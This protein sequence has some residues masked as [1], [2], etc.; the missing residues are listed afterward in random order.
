MIFYYKIIILVIRVILGLELEKKLRDLV[1]ITSIEVHDDQRNRSEDIRFEACDDDSKE[2]I[3]NPFLLKKTFHWIKCNLI[4]Y[5]VVSL[6]WVPV[7]DEDYDIS[8][9]DICFSSLEEEPNQEL[10]AI[11][12]F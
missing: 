7:Q 3:F 2:C 9:E 11:F 12:F 10:R 8:N 5:K 6:L 1:L 4:V